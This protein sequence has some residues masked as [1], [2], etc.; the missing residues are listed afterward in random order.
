[1]GDGGN[2][3]ETNGACFCMRDACVRKRMQLQ[4]L[5]AA[6]RRRREEELWGSR[7]SR[8]GHGGVHQMQGEAPAAD[9]AMQELRVGRRQEGQGRPPVLSASTHT[10]SAAATAAAAAALLAAAAAAAASLPL[11]GALLRL[12]RFPPTSQIMAAAAVFGRG[13]RGFL[14]LRLLSDL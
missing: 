12:Q 13:A 9:Q 5:M 10:L 3:L 4:R 11:E 14:L 1:M 7:A 2:S 6:E 8:E